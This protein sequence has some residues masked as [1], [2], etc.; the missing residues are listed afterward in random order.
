MTVQFQNAHFQDGNAP[1]TLEGSLR[2][3]GAFAGIHNYDVEDLIDEPFDNLDDWTADVVGSYTIVSGQLNIV[4]AGASR[5]YRIFHDE[6]VAPSFV[7]SLDLVS[8]PGAIMFL[9]AD[10]SKAFSAWWTTSTCGFSLVHAGG[11]T[12]D[13]LVQLPV[14]ITAPSR[15]QL[16]VK[17]SLDS[18]NENIRWMQATLFADGQC[19]VGHTLDIGGTAYSWTGTGIGL[20]TTDS[21]TLIVDNLTVSAFSKIIEWTTVDIGDSPASGASRAV[22]TTRLARQARFDGTIHIW[23]PGNRDEDWAVPGYRPVKVAYRDAKTEAITHVRSRGVLYEADYFDDD[24]GAV[25]MHRFHLADNPNLLSREET[26]AEAQRVLHEFLEKQKTA[27][28]DMPSNPLL[29]PF[30]RISYDGADWRIQGIQRSL[31]VTGVSIVPKAVID[32]RQYLELVLEE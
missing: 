15:V 26:Y 23:R 3:T 2:L 21:N 14:G 28:I 16:A 24:E 5:Y 25:H 10:D 19:V 20:A 9:G 4:G 31:A 30:D 6:S 8:G 32:T 22:G 18:V 29:E 1:I 17:Y 7:V 11:I 12:E 13:K 27:Q